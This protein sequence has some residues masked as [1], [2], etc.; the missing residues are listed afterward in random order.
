VKQKKIKRRVSLAVL[1]DFQEFRGGEARGA[2][3]EGF[4]V[5]EALVPEA[6][7]AESGRSD[8]ES[9]CGHKKIGRRM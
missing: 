5:R 4:V 1:Q 9:G 3:A 7:K 8:A 2:G 6:E